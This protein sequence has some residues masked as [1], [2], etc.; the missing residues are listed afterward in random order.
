MTPTTT[1]AFRVRDAIERCFWTGVVAVIGTAP[2]LQ[3]AALVTNLDITALQTL[4]ATGISTMLS[5]GINFL[6]VFARHRLS[7]LPEPGQGLPGL[8]VTTI[9]PMPSPPPEPPAP[10]GG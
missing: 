9:P 8:P 10:S 2:S 6:L 7:V 5:T 4:A 1:T 3:L